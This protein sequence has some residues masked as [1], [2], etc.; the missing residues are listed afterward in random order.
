MD[1]NGPSPC[2]QVE[3]AREDLKAIGKG[4]SCT[5]SLLLCCRGH[6]DEATDAP[7][8]GFTGSLQTLLRQKPK[9]HH[10]QE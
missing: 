9:Q 4:A 2:G 6:D 5:A 1:V 7:D 8:T 3:F 10:E